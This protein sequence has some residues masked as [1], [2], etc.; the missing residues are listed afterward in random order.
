MIYS[1]FVILI[2]IYSHIHKRMDYWL[3]WKTKQGKG[4]VF[5]AVQ[6]NSPHQAHSRTHT[7]VHTTGIEKETVKSEF[8]SLLPSFFLWC[9]FFCLCTIAPAISW[10]F[11]IFAFCVGFKLANSKIYAV[12]SQVVLNCER[13]NI[14]LLSFLFADLRHFIKWKFCFIWFS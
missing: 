7:Y 12:C 10:P 9:K 6:Q 5:W 8:F 13:Y 2:H 14:F 4:Q 11:A 1:D 3:A